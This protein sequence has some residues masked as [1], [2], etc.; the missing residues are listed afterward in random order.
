MFS[1]TFIRKGSGRLEDMVFM[2]PAGSPSKVLLKA[3]YFKLGY[4]QTIDKGL[5]SMV[6]PCLDPAKID[7][8]A[9]EKLKKASDHAQNGHP[10]IALQGLSAVVEEYSK[11]DNPKLLKAL[12][13]QTIFAINK[14][15]FESSDSAQQAVDVL[16][17]IAGRYAVSDPEIS[18]RATEVCLRAS[19]VIANEA[20]YARGAELLRTQVTHSV[21]SLAT[22]AQAG[23]N[24]NRESVTK[25]PPQVSVPS[26]KRPLMPSGDVTED[27][28][29]YTDDELSADNIA[30]FEQA[31]AAMKTMC[32][33]SATM[34]SNTM[35]PE[36]D[37]VVTKQGAFTTVAGR[38]YCDEM[39]AGSMQADDIVVQPSEECLQQNVPIVDILMC[40]TQKNPYWFIDNIPLISPIVYLKF[41][42]TGRQRSA[43]T[44]DFHRELF[45]ITVLNKK[46]VDIP[47]SVHQATLP[48]APLSSLDEFSFNDQISMHRIYVFRN[49]GFTATLTHFAKPD[50]GLFQSQKKTVTFSDPVLD[51]TEVHDYDSFWFLSV[52]PTDQMVR[53]GGTKY[54]FSASSTGCFAWN[55][56]GKNWDYACHAA[57]GRVV[58]TTITCYCE[59]GEVFTAYVEDNAANL[60]ENL[61]ID[62]ALETRFCWVL[63]ITVAAT[64]FVFLLLFFFASFE[65]PDHLLDRVFFVGDVPSFYHCAYVVAIKTGKK[66][67]S[68][69]TSNVTIKL[70]GTNSDSLAHVLNYPDPELVMFQKNTEI[71]FVMATEK[72]L[73]DLVG[74]EIWFDSIGNDTNWYCSRIEVYDIQEDKSWRFE[75]NQWFDVARP[76]HQKFL[77]T[78][79]PVGTGMLEKGGTR[80]V[81]AVKTLLGRTRKELNL[82]NVLSKDPLMTRKERLALL[83]LTLISI[84]LILMLMYAI[85]NFDESD[86]IDGNTFGFNAKLIW[87]PVV[88]NLLAFLLTFPLIYAIKRGKI[89]TSKG[90]RP[91][92]LLAISSAVVTTVSWGSVVLLST[93]GLTVLI[94]CGFWIP[95]DTSLLWLVS[96][97]LAVCFNMVITQNI[98]RLFYGF[99]VQIPAQIQSFQ[100]ATKR[101][102]QFVELQRSWIYKKF[103]PLALRPYLRH[104]Y[105]SLD[106]ITLKE[107]FKWE[108][109]KVAIF[110][111]LEDLMMISVYVALLYVLLMFDRDE[112][113]IHSHNE[114]ENLLLGKAVNSKISPDSISQIEDYLAEVLLPTV[115]S[116]E[117]YGNY[118]QEN[119]GMTKDFSNKY[120]GIIRLRQHRTREIK[121]QLPAILAKVPWTCRPDFHM[122]RETS[123]FSRGWKAPSDISQITT[124]R[125]GN[126]WKYTDSSLSGSSIYFGEYAAY[127][128]GGYVAPLGRHLRNSLINLEYLKKHKW[129]D[130]Q[131]RALFI[132]FLTYNANVNLFNGVTVIFE[133]NAAGHVSKDLKV[134]T[135]K[136]LMIDQDRVFT[137]NVV[138]TIFVLALLVLA[139]RIAYKIHRKKTLYFYDVW[140][141]LDIVIVFLSACSIYLYY[142]R[143]HAIQIYIDAVSEAKN[144]DFV[145][146][147]Q[148]FAADNVL[149]ALSATLVFVAT[150]RLW[151]LL[152]FMIIVKVAEKTVRDAGTSLL[153]C[154]AYQLLLVVAF[155]ATGIMFFG[156][157]SQ[158]FKNFNSAFSTLLLLSLNLCGTLEL[159]D[160]YKHPLGIAFYILYMLVS[161]F[162][163]NI[164]IAIISLYYADSKD[165]YADEPRFMQ[166]FVQQK[167]KFYKNLLMVRGR[168][169]RGGE[170]EINDDRIIKPKSGERYQDCF[171]IAKSRLDGMALVT[172]CV[173][174]NMEEH[175]SMTEKDFDLM[176]KTI[177]LL[178][179]DESTDKQV[180]FTTGDSRRIT[181]VDDRKIQQIADICENLVQYCMRKTRV[182]RHLPPSLIDERISRINTLIENIRMI[183]SV[184]GNVQI[185]HK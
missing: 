142:A 133:I 58:A 166:K 122:L 131:T 44:V 78:P 35:V 65:Q 66:R 165:F 28:A 68:G 150:L 53:S 23:L 69:T 184:L 181:F 88:A 60:E 113:A 101:F 10:S 87:A 74:M 31:A 130:I 14:I 139:L 120:L 172:I 134:Q 173:L 128:G 51:V 121:C 2:L 90:K 185:R 94:V 107:R 154:W 72:S 15:K 180:F 70:N 156:G 159:N 67:H 63:Y 169:M 119:P 30:R 13:Q 82:W 91:H 138:S 43:I 34:L 59:Y 75:V 183:E 106:P 54:S 136:F 27:Y 8:S 161:F 116:L 147:F 137:K 97:A 117:W 11:V 149:T 26:T 81:K 22:C 182:S 29:D 102:I 52:L 124:E 110:E 98:S 80:V 99:L 86:T 79:A 17:H 64:F 36:E 100:A 7:E 151:K 92:R 158:N 118:V 109:T 41:T 45:K 179:E 95:F 71:W 47:L 89:S 114:I 93:A 177:K 1:D 40:S 164:Y 123:S 18:L 146:Y 56:T 6:A 24:E 127:P 73:G 132:E 83:F 160:L 105:F 39:A 21:K 96:A 61:L 175:R 12:D 135:R 16:G 4:T 62:F 157:Y 20:K 50:L 152:R 57:S 55:E 84:Y 171:T 153:L 176:S 33:T 104:L 85:P 155:S 143:Q 111:I 162:F 5:S 115:Q 174:R 48:T 103:G 125:M 9:R 38:M 178:H 3:T 168:K 108:E 112:Q 129:L 141:I 32:F 37:P 145:Q 170:D 46:E 76:D 144:N 77:L 42:G 25:S 140:A 167:W 19:K 49:R 126:V 163:I 148:L